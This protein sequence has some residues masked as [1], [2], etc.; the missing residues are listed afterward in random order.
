[1]KWTK[2]LT[3]KLIRLYPNTPNYELTHIF[4]VTEKTITSKAYKIGLKK[5]KECKSFLIGKRN[6]MVGRDLNYDNLKK[7]ALNY[8]TRGEFQYN[9]SSAYTVARK[10]GFL[11]EICAHMSVIKFSI[12]QL[13]LQDI[14]DNLF[15]LKS[16]YETRQIIKPY[17][18]DIYYPQLKL[19]FEYQGKLWHTPKYNNNRDSIK[20]KLAK[21]LGIRLIYIFENNRRYEEDIKNQIIDNLN[22]INELTNIKI[23]KQDVINYVV[24]DIY[25]KLYNKDELINIAKSYTS[26]KEFVKSENKVYFKLSRLHLLDEAT[27]HMSDRL[28]RRNEVEVKEIIKRYI[29]LGD[30]IK[31]DYA[32]YLFIKRNKLEHLISH[33]KSRF[34]K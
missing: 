25:S 33:L 3:D 22:L 4:S 13:I 29:T 26:F 27:A 16:V 14:M 23:N 11:N 9:D 19:G 18:I 31:N 15:N 32:T 8:K 28:L 20:N 2:E 5:T 1:M 12:P 10:K 17:E 34:N 21:D 24:G 6:K 30:L 7:I